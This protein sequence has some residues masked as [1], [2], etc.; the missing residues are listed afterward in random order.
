MGHP[1]RQF[2]NQSYSHAFIEGFFSPTFGLLNNFLRS[3]FMSDAQILIGFSMTS[4]DNACV[5]CVFAFVM[6]I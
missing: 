6:L 3:N 1:A 5:Q 4:D 2:D